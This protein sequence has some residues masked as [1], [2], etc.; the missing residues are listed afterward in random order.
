MLGSNTISSSQFFPGGIP[1]GVYPF[2]VSDGNGCVKNDTITITQPN[3]LTTINNVTDISCYGL[4][5]G[6]V[7]LNIQGGT[8]PFIENWG[9]FNPNALAQG[10]Y[11]FTVTDSNNCSFSDSISIIEP[12]SFYYST[13][14]NNISCYGFNDG[15]VSFIMNGGTPPYYENWGASDPL[16]LSPG[17]HYFTVSDTNGCSISDSVN[18]SEPSELIVSITST[19]ITCYGG[20]NG[21]A[22]LSISGGTLPYNENW[23]GFDPMA[24]IAGTYIYTVNDT[25]NC[26][27]TDSVT[28]T[29][30][31][32]SLTST[33]VPTNLSSCLI[34]DGSIDQNI[35]GGTPPYTYLWNNGDTTQDISNLM[36]GTY[37]VTTTDTNGCFT[38]ST[39]FVDQPSDSLRL[40]LSTQDF[41]GYNIACYGDTNGIISAITTG[42]HGLI[43][44]NW[45][46]G[47][48]NSTANNLYAGSFSVTI[49][50]TSGCSL[51]DSTI[52]ISPTQL[53]SSYTTTDVLCY[54]DSTGSATVIFN[55]GVPDYLLGWGSFTLPLLNGQNTFASGT[56]IPQGVYPYS[57]TDLNGCTLFL[58][59]IHI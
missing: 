57:A 51:T 44:Y 28:I 5:D 48:T 10:T 15:N 29:Q 30:S 13:Q 37:S 47:D 3:P 9:G 56:I 24:L 8:P 49:T 27:V 26:S 45:S 53:T 35:I 20:N 52:L 36:A 11:F 34:M 12:D 17:M 31:Q 4:T 18:I 1:A 25:N 41:N 46:T 43:S 14:V 55:G 40:N 59:L 7:I 33:L 21:T 22:S 50:D 42:G 38:I 58:S 39:I 19:N 2:S 6:S 54:N 23:Y 32:D 16:A